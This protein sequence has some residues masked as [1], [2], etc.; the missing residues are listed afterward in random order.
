[1]GLN[2]L[3]QQSA[4]NKTNKTNTSR[5]VLNQA[6][7]NRKEKWKIYNGPSQVLAAKFWKQ[8]GAILKK[9]NKKKII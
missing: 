5:A 9:R 6:L 7:S 2:N 4:L 8:A 1:M 3:Y